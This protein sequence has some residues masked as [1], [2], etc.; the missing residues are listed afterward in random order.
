M[1][2]IL[3]PVFDEEY[4]IVFMVAWAT[5]PPVKQVKTWDTLVRKW[6]VSCDRADA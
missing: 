1:Q 2:G 6:R 3:F 5:P 4:S